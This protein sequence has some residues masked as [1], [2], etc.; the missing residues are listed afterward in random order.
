MTNKEKTG[1]LKEALQNFRALISLY[2][3][4][5]ALVWKASPYAFLGCLTTSILSGLVPPVQVWLLKVIIDRVVIGIEMNQTGGV[6]DLSGII[7]LLGF[8]LGVMA[9]S[10]ALHA[11]YTMSRE[12]VGRR[13]EY[14]IQQLILQKTAILDYAFFED[15]KFY[16]MLTNAS[17]DATW[18]P[19]NFVWLLVEI[20]RDSLTIIAMILILARLHILA[21]VAIA[22]VPLVRLVFMRWHVKR[23][24]L[25]DMKYTTM[26]RIM[27][28][29][30]DLMTSRES[31]KEIRIFALFDHLYNRYSQYK[32]EHVK[33]YEKLRFSGTRVEWLIST[34]SNVIGVGVWAYI[35]IRAL[36]GHITIGD[37]TLFFQAVSSCQQ[38]FDGMSQI[39]VQG[40]EN[41]LFITNLSAFLDLHPQNVEGALKRSEKPT[42]TLSTKVIEKD[43]EFRNVSFK[44]PGQDRYVLRDVSFNIRPAETVAIVG[45]NGAGKTTLVKLLARFYDPTAGEIL[46]DGHNLVEYDIAAFRQQM[47]IVFQDFLQYQLTIRDNIAFGEIEH[48]GDTDRMEKAAEDSGAMS[49]IQ[50]LPDKFDTVLGRTL[51][52]GVDLSGGEWQKLGL[53]RAFF[54]DAEILI[55]DEPTAALDPLSEYELFE[56][57][58]RL[59]ENKTGVIISHRFSTVRMADRIIVLEDGEC[60]EQGSHTELLA[61]G[62]MYAKLFTTQAKYYHLEDV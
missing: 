30:H 7:W 3:R 13:V 15:P 59:T 62:G 21:A 36:Y 25:M 10:A 57:F 55:L 18:R 44:Y 50:R 32:E 45:R 23:R 53:A 38:R 20:L 6:V 58:A 28:Y 8:Y 51:Q 37:I 12:F 27:R 16:N 9:V 2:P 41:S 40:Y 26:R 49:L 24:F 52:E 17:Q 48:A 61:R 33:E 29:F 14:Y 11:L 39:I 34:F 4:I 31:I 1:S 54:R 22:I 42:R 56:R 5:T 43:I 46:L 47:S 60:I 35:I 19:A